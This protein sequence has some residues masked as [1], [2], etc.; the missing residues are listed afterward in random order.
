[1]SAAIPETLRICPACD[2]LVA[3]A[4]GLS[5]GSDPYCPGCRAQIDREDAI[6]HAGRA[7]AVF[8][9]IP[10]QEAMFERGRC[11][12]LRLAVIASV[13]IWLAAGLAY[14]G[15]WLLGRL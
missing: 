2:S 12:G 5:G 8:D 1:M 6:Y 10:R 13:A 15:G 7:A 9:G 14:A 3:C 4:A 11:G